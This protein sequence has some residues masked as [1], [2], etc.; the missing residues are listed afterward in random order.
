[1]SF[2]F[3]QLLHLCPGHIHKPGLY[4]S[5][6]NG[7]R[8]K[9]TI[10]RSRRRSGWLPAA[11]PVLCTFFFGASIQAATFTVNDLGDAVDAVIDGTCETATGNGICT[12]RAAIME[13]NSN[14]FTADVITLPAGTIN[15]T[16]GS[17]SSDIDASVG[18]LDISNGGVTITG[19]GV[20]TTIVGAGAGFVHRIFE[21][22]IDL[23]STPFGSVTFE[24]FTIQGGNSSGLG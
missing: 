24:D 21:I 3:W 15:L 23:Y 20:G 14:G 16:I 1:M 7:L 11:L 2:S 9:P 12:L 4:F 19:L 13:A 8:T 18:D 22:P 6:P 5:R 10:A 17:G